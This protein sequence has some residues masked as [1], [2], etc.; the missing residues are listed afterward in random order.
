M[1]RFE[2]QPVATAFVSMLRKRA[3]WQSPNTVPSSRRLPSQLRLGDKSI[4]VRI[5][6]AEECGWEFVAGEWN[7]FLVETRLPESPENAAGQGRG[8]VEATEAPVADILA[9]SVPNRLKLMA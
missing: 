8:W 2:T 7:S 1:R 9:G 5:K 3:H 4:F 6:L